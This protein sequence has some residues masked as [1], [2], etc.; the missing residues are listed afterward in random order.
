MNIKQKYTKDPI[1]GINNNCN[2]SARPIVAQVAYALKLEVHEDANG[3][4]AYGKNNDTFIRL[5]DHC[6]YLQTWVDGGSYGCKN[7]YD[8]VIE[9]NPTLA[10]TSVKSGYM[11]NVLEYV[12][13]S[14]EMDYNMVKM[15]AYD[16][17][18]TLNGNSYP[19]NIRGEKRIV[20]ATNESFEHKIKAVLKEVI[21]KF[22]RRNR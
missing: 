16:I 17:R 15:L 20:S 19:N 21:N 7:K 13:S 10:K 9:D 12:K 8:I 3:I 11:F 1:K 22:L 18:T 2:Y 6:T 14:K 4:S 5:S